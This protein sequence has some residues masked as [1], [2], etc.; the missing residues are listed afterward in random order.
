MGTLFK[1]AFENG[2]IDKHPMDGVKCQAARKS[3]SDIKVL[4]VEEQTKFLEAA[5][6]SQYYDQY[7]L[8]LQTG[9]AQGNLLDSLGARLI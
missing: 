5:K 4:T 6:R 1:A 2:V 8:L 9:Y 7:V 3:M